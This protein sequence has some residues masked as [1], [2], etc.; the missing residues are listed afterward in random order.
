MSKPKYFGTDGI[1]G[2]VGVNPLT[3]E[4]VLRLGMAAGSVLKELG[5][6]N[7]IVIGR[8]TRQ[9]G[10][11]LQSALTAGLLSAGVNVMD[12][13]VMTTPGV[14]YLVRKLGAA[15]GVV[16][17]A[18]HNPVHENGIKFFDH[19]GLKLQED[20]EYEIERRMDSAPVEVSQYGRSLDGK[21]M[22]ELY[23][24]SLLDEHLGLRL[25]HLSIVLDCAN[26]A[27]SWFAPECLARLGARVIAIHASPTGLNIN[28]R[29]GSE[30]TRQRPAEL[31][32]LIQ[33][34]QANFAITFDGDADRVIF[35]D[36]QGCVIDGDHMLAL[37][38]RYLDSR[39]ELA[40]RTIVTTLMRNEG[41]VKF[42]RQHD[43]PLHETP[44]GD[45]YIVEKLLEL[46]ALPGSQRFALG[47]EQ[48]GHVILVD[49]EH[50]TGDGIRTGLFVL[51]AFVQSDAA[52]LSEFANTIQKTPQVI[53][54]A[55]V[56]GGPRLDRKGLDEMEA[57]ARLKVPSLTRV[58]LRYSGTEALF[59]A[60]LEADLPM[61][62]T[63][64]ARFAW[65]ICRTIQTRAGEPEGRIEILNVSRGGMID[66]PG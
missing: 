11:M 45:K 61:S 53:A 46:R 48:S 50:T 19:L 57:Q 41:L 47:G 15:A 43:M 7:T 10:P 9:S 38:A 23:V 64:L 12:A 18:S 4:F 40:A 3:P 65:E 31:A 66:I 33:H 35:V 51:N 16:I 62:E 21:G 14:A 59:R 60:M 24:D 1:R 29:A 63:E 36:E 37:L 17:S 20:V 54:S 13:G 56:G 58:N 42:A 25:D 32:W 30:H 6:E 2:V 55:F 49:G 5:G 22:H 39:G 44:V 52:T 34:Y 26:G 28:D 8:D 27:A